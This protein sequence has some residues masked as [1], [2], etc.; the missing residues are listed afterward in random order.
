MSISR[1]EDFFVLEHLE[2]KYDVPI[3]SEWENFPEAMV[4]SGGG[5]NKHTIGSVKRKFE[6]L[7]DA[8]SNMNATLDKT[9][10]GSLPLAFYMEELPG[11]SSNAQILLLVRADMANF[12]VRRV[13]VDPAAMWTSCT[14]TSSKL[15]S[16]TSVT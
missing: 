4:I 13:L 7:I 14:P 16:S 15:C 2:D 12:E 6:E 1:P 10:S 5:F 9:K 3:L 8:S 11:G